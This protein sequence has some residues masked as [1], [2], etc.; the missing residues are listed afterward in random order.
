MGDGGGRSHAHSIVEIVDTPATEG[1]ERKRCALGWMS[2][3]VADPILSVRCSNLPSLIFHAGQ[4]HVDHDNRCK[5]RAHHIKN[6]SLPC[7]RR[8]WRVRVSMAL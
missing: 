5:G 4:G 1:S 6:W 2:Q 8:D 3:I 7:R